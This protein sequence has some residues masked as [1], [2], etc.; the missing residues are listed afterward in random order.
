MF[1]VFVFLAVF[2]WLFVGVFLFSAADFDTGLDIDADLDGDIDMDT[3]LESHADLSNSAAHLL[4][5]LF[6]FRSLVFFAAFFGLTGVL[7]TWLDTNIVVTILIA[8]GL[9]FFAAF[10]NVKLMDYLKRTSVSSQLTDSTIAGNTANVVVP[11][12][13]GHK[14][15]V[16][17]DVNG[18]RIY[19]VAT[20]YNERHQDEFAVGDSV[21]VV[22]VKNGAALITHMDKF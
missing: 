2:G 14:G 11:V 8:V 4:G 10:I 7:L 17:V 19:L 20:P 3:D 21:V 9:G 12:G 6:S 5:A 1:G 15:K 13:P 16:A 22:E 18:Q